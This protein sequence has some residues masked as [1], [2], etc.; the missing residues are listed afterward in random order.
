MTCSADTERIYSML[1]GK[2]L[3]RY[4]KKFDW[5]LQT[6]MMGKRTMESAQVFVEESGLTGILSPEAFLEER[7]GMLQELLPT[8]SLLPGTDLSFY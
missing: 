4:G 7:Q 1:N 2:I 5:Q 8:C 3:A 6:K